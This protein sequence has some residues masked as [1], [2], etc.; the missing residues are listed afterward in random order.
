MSEFVIVPVRRRTNPVWPVRLYF[1]IF[2]NMNERDTVTALAALA[3]GS[4]L[5]VYR[6][7][8]QRGPD[9]YPAGEISARIGRIAGDYVAYQQLYPQILAAAVTE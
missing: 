3:Q 5:A 1:D 6:L 9:G 2:G 7:L 4:R 8:V